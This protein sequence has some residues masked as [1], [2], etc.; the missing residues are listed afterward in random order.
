[1]PQNR[2]LRR[3]ENDL[4]AAQDALPQIP[5]VMAVEDAPKP[6]DVR[7]HVRGETQTLGA[8]APRGFPEVLLKICP[9]DTSMAVTPTTSG[10]LAFAR[11]LT[12]PK[13]P[14]TSR[15]AVNR[16]WQALFGTGLVA[17]PDNWGLTG[18]KPSHPELLDY[19]AATF[20]QEDNWSQKKL[21]RRLMLSSTYQMDVTSPTVAQAARIDPEN[22]LLWRM[23]RRRLEAEP[24]RDA[25][26]YVAGKLDARIGG[27]LLTTRD[28]D[29]VTNDQSADN[30]L[31]DAPRRSLYLPVIRNSVYGLFQAFDFGDGTT[32]NA[33]RASTTVA[34]QALFL[35][36]SPLVRDAAGTFA[37][38][39]LKD[40]PHSDF[41]RIRQAYYRA[42]GRPAT[43]EEVIRS[44]AF[45]YRY[46]TALLTVEPDAAK[47]QQRVWQSYCQALY[48]SN[49]FS[50][51]N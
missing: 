43:H 11:W 18:E 29:Y 50:Y 9:A 16:I 27:S 25:L 47:R 17:T 7:I 44:M 6:E 8:V 14:L 46:E 35:L 2:R 20:T 39:L 19:L 26:L 23:N 12:L 49:E 36:N 42:L 28:N 37:Q 24:L 38:S 33:H 10:R 34:P 31:Y 4:K 41:D 48:A 13:H 51:V 32:V 5:T 21:I 3:G 22:R 1:M 15:V 45:L 30:A 40:V